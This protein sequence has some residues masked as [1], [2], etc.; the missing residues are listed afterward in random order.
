M[1]GEPKHADTD[2]TGLDIWVINSVKWIDFV[3]YLYI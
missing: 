2:N 3:I 1:S